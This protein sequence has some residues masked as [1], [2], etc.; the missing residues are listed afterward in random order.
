M[1]SHVKAIVDVA[2]CLIAHTRIV[3]K[4]QVVDA[5]IV[6]VRARESLLFD[7]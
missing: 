1:V 2:V 6:G 4:I 3:V 7:G 5:P